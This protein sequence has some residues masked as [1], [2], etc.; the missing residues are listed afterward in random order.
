VASTSGGSLF[1]DGVAFAC[2]GGAA[3]TA[4]FPCSTVA[5]VAALTAATAATCWVGSRVGGGR[6]D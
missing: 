4:S 3:S 1:P 5:A 6:G 2:W